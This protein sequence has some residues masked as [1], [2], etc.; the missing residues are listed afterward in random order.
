MHLTENAPGQLDMPMVLLVALDEC[1]ARRLWVASQCLDGRSRAGRVSGQKAGHGFSEKLFH[2]W[3]SR[4][5]SSHEYG[6]NE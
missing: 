3:R 6:F 4:A 2:I 5:H 1:F